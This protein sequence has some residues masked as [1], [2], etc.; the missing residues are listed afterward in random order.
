M[1]GSSNVEVDP[2]FKFLSFNLR[3]VDMSTLTERHAEFRHVSPRRDE[4]VGFWDE[5][6]SLEEFEGETDFS[7]FESFNKDIPKLGVRTIDIRD[8]S[9]NKIF[10]ISIGENGAAFSVSN[11]ASLDILVSD[12]V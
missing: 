6:G 4:L 9:N 7:C 2:V 12:A 5:T 8:S 10:S 1:L 3:N 11:K